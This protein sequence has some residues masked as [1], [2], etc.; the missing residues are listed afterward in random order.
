MIRLEPES[1]NIFPYFYPQTHF[2]VA[3]NGWNLTWG[4]LGNTPYFFDSSL[5]VTQ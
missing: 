3:S 5:N 4:L 1:E 2:V